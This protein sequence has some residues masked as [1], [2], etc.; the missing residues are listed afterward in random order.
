MQP[1]QLIVLGGPTAS[2]KSALA[3]GLA[4]QLISQGQRAEILCADSITVYRGFEIG[5]AKPDTSD[6][7][8]VPHHL[9]DLI[10]ADQSFT[11]ADFVKAADPIV[12]RLLSDEIVPILAGGSGF[13]LR[14]LLRGMAGEEEDQTASLA[15]KKRLE[16][17]GKNEGWEKLHS[18]LVRL[19]PGSA[20]IVHPNDHY[21]IVRALQ[22]M[23]IHR[24]PW[25]ELNSRARA[26]PPKFPF[27]YFRLE[28]SK[29]EIRSKVEKRTALML[30]AGLV[31]EVRS[32]LDS[33]VA[34]D[35]KPMQSVGYKE[36]VEF[37]EGLFPER[38]LHGRIVMGTMK[39]VKSQM[40]WFK[41][42]E[43]STSLA[44]P[45]FENLMTQM[46]ANKEMAR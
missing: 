12:S 46:A 36:A 39:L 1:P 26:T 3:L 40:T 8:R 16:E 45:F 20:P 6:R 11:A 34:P 4:E 15:V 21:R 25:S 31:P 22:A 5:A 35:S 19:D 43:L 37:L 2:G 17:R 24:K 27:R 30:Q 38:E 44:P 33:G 29:D 42:E 13:Y 14:A 41:G 28:L 10:D 23:E 9:L 7:Q 32:L 18:E